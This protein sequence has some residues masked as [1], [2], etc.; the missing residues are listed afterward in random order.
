MFLF[1]CIYLI[2]GIVTMYP[3][4]LLGLAIDETKIEELKK[5][6]FDFWFSLGFGL[7]GLRFFITWP[8]WILYM[9]YKIYIRDDE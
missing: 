9:V 1:I 7:G 4:A 6:G 5:E 3:I 2:I 8:Y